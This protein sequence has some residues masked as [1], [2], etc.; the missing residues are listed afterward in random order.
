MSH[1]APTKMYERSQ[2]VVP[3]WYLV[4]PKLAQYALLSVLDTSNKQI[5]F[6]FFFIMVLSTNTISG[7]KTDVSKPTTV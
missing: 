2:S 6:F 1:L 7:S 5:I 3:Q 4:G